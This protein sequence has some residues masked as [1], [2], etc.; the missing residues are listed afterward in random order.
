MIRVTGDNTKLA[1][2]RLMKVESVPPPRQ[3]TLTSLYHPNSFEKLDKSIV[4][5]YPKPNSFTGEDV[6]EFNIHGGR[7]VISSVLDALHVVPGLRHAEAGDFV[8]RAFLNGKLDLTE[9]EGLDDLLNAETDIQRKLALSQ[10]SGSLSILY[11]SWRRDLLKCLSHREAVIDFADD[12]ED[13]DHDLLDKVTESVNILKKNIYKHLNDGN[14]GE[15]IR[16]GI[17]IALIGPPNAGDTGFFL[18]ESI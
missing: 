14:K 1:L 13:V 11:E 8:R 2:K 7:A 4:I 3:A 10:M 15:I 17:S 9:V 12:E 16:N 6:A 18:Y 5:Y